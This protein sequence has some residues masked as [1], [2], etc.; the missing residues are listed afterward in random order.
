MKC[1]Y[2]KVCPNLTDN[3]WRSCY[4]YIKFNNLVNQLNISDKAV[5][6]FLA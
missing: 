1:V 3:C 2:D 5:T 4:R 6:T